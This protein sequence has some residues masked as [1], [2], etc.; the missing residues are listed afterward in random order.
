MGNPEGY[1]DV[2]SRIG[3][4]REEDSRSA[5]EALVE[6]DTLG[7]GIAWV[8]PPDAETA[9]FNR[10]GNEL[11]IGAVRDYPGRLVGCA[12]ANP[13]FGE[14]A[15]QELGRAFDG[16]LRA[17]FLYPRI[18]G[19]QLSDPLFE[20]LVETAIDHRAPI[21]VHTST[22]IASEPLQLAYLA[23]R[24]PRGLFIMGHMG[25]PDFWYDAIPAAEAAANLWLETSRID[26]DL[27]AEAVRA[28][29][30]ERV[31]FGSDA[32]FCAPEVE[33][34]KI[35][36]LDM[37]PSQIALIMRQNALRLLE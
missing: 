21:Y 30:A 23:K 10:R 24:H 9:V 1:I 29:G 18:Q 36:S 3:V 11:L 32:P 14:A 15:V 31:L 34:A 8:C 19:F 26:S 17:L 16:G 37:P 12:V 20:P 33:A 28:V 13:W 6:M 35:L 27:I 22:P 4:G 7:I 5:E 25:Y 2:H